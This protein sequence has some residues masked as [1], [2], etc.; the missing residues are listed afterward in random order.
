M[1]PARTT[2]KKKTTLRPIGMPRPVMVRIDRAHPDALPLAVTRTD[3]RGKRGVEA[4]V[5]VVDE[6]WRIAEA[7]WRE[8]GPMTGNGQARTY[9]R[10][11]L[12]GGRP[13]TIFRDEAHGGWFEQPYSAGQARH[14]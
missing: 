2:P 10:V 14:P 8:G 7:W 4:R 13:L 12:E 6:V 1:P 11:I 5:E 9:Y 3:A